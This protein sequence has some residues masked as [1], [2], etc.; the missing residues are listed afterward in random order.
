MKCDI[1]KIRVICKY[2]LFIFLYIFDIF[3]LY[4]FWLR[5]WR[6]RDVINY[7]DL[8]HKGY[9]DMIEMY[10]GYISGWSILFALSLIYSVAYIKNKPFYAFIWLLLPVFYLGTLMYHEYL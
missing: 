6:I 10:S 1:R 5:S 8:N 7:T 4:F 9:L 2:F 3:N